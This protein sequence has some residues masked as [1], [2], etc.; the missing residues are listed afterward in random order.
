[1]VLQKPLGNLPRNNG[2]FR[3]SH[4]MGDQILID[5]TRIIKARIRSTDSVYRIGGEE[6]VVV[7]EGESLE[8][9][10]RLAEQLRTLIEANSMLPEGAVTVSLGVAEHTDGES[11]MQWCH[12]AD[13]AL[14]LLRSRQA[15]R[16]IA[17]LGLTDAFRAMQ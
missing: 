3:D 2:R 11:A 12:R 7:A 13:D 1:M 16:R 4:A 15:F 14:Y 10:F 17:N 5:V 8:S 6:F 9:A